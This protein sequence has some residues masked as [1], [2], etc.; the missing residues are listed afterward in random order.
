VDKSQRQLDRPCLLIQVRHSSAFFFVWPM[1]VSGGPV[2]M[3]K[4]TS[5]VADGSLVAAKL[6]NAKLYNHK[7]GS[8]AGE[9]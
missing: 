3:Y 1:D 5:N 7:E 9:G 4:Q 6:V 8:Q 2:M